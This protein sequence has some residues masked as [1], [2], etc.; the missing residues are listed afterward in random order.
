MLQLKIKNTDKNLS[1]FK[2]ITKKSSGNLWHLSRLFKEDGKLC[3][4]YN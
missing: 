1:E 3:C 2:T 4:N